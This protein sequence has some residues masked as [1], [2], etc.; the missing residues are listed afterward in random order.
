MSYIRPQ[1]LN[2]AYDM[3]LSYFLMDTGWEDVIPLF[4]Q[5]LKPVQ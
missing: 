2:Q 4:N 5:E 3:P 1:L